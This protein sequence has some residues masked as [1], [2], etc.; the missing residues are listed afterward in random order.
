MFC[1]LL[2]HMIKKAKSSA[3]ISFT[4]TVYIQFNIDLGFIGMPRMHYFSKA[5]L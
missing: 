3:N 1:N 2:Q 4:F 5:I